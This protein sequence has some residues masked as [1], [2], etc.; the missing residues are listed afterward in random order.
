MPIASLNVFFV[1]GVEIK[2]SGTGEIIQQ[3][4]YLPHTFSIEKVKNWGWRDG[5]GLRPLVP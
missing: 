5:T 4:A 1:N 2:G 3:P